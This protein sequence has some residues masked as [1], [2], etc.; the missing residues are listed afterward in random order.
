VVG[1][2]LNVV[3]S[4]PV[5]LVL[6]RHLGDENFGRWATLMTIVQLVGLLGELQ[7]EQA[8]VKA[9]A[10]GDADLDELLGALVGLRLL[11]AIPAAVICMVVALAIAD[12]R[13]MAACGVVLSTVIVVYALG[14]GK[15]VFQVNV[16][17]DIPVL[18]ATISTVLW[19]LSVL[20]LT[21]RGAELVPLAIAYVATTGVMIIVQAILVRRIARPNAR[22]GR[23]HWRA[24]LRL[25]APM[26][27]AIFLVTSYAR[28]DQVLVYALAGDRAASL[29]GAIYRVLDQA[30][31]IPL[32]MIT[33]LFPQIVREAHAR[34]PRLN[35]LIGVCADFMAIVSLPA[36][37]ASLVIAEPL[38]TFMFG[39]QFADSAPALLPLMGAFV[40]TSFGLLGSYVVIALDGQKRYALF[41]G[42]GLAFNLL[43][44]VIL[45]PHFGFVAAAWVTLATELLVATLLLAA[46]VREVDLRL[47]PRRM[48]RAAAASV[49]M[50]LALLFGEQIGWSVA[51]LIP[52]ASAIYVFALVLTR[53]L[54]PADLRRLLATR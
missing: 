11:L 46:I 13:D 20:V 49:V 19:T 24:T 32:A 7:L 31:V 5:T 54:T 28:I 25:G 15:A 48:M 36:L 43:A 51:V 41:A 47:S 14:A 9:A 40:V 22:R 52:V 8:T 35:E 2:V 53:A 45:V 6:I 42:G 44:N 17:N 33:T 29:Y 16:R 38:V 26:G 3:L 4:L 18:L 39:S 27:L 37:M 10:R 23:R 21:A 1:R 50:G 12:T 34:S 30:R